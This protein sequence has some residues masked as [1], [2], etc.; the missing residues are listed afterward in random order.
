MPQPVP[1]PLRE[2]L[3]QAH[4]AMQQHPQHAL[5]PIYRYKIYQAMREAAGSHADRV[6]VQLALL[7]ARKV[8]PIWYEQRPND[9]WPEQ[10]MATAESI[11]QGHASKEAGFAL[12]Q[13]AFDR[14]VALG[15]EWRGP[16]TAEINE[17]AQSAAEA[18]VQALYEASGIFHLSKPQDARENETNADLDPWSSDPALWAEM[19]YT[20]GVW[21][22]ASDLQR[23]E[24]FWEWWL[25]EAIPQAWQKGRGAGQR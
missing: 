10:L 6:R 15:S 5:L 1:T 7:S 11:V 25:F 18:A 13:R 3:E 24:E 19:A 2:V 17:Y 20:G 8:L 9:P 21:D 12:A 23:R 4:H 16:G 22:P 14:V